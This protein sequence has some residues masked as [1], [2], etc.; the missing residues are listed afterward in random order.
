MTLISAPQ[1]AVSGDNM[2]LPSVALP[3]A[4]PDQ[5][6]QSREAA[7]REVA[8]EFETVFLAEMLKHTGLGEARE[9]FGGGAGEEAFSGLLATEQARIM[10]E[11][12][13]IGLAERIYQA[14]LN[15]E[16]GHV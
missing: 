13:G 5:P 16:D 12:G 7:L 6:G 15:R 3:A 8:V 1:A 14:L 4:P 2:N 9:S 11:R 10:A